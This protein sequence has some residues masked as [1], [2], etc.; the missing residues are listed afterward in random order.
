[1]SAINNHHV[2]EHNL[3]YL[4]TTLIQLSPCI[5]VRSFSLFDGGCV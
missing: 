1:V 4:P 5:M 3:T 2:L